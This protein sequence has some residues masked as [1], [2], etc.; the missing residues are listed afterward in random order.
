[1]ESEV[2]KYFGIAAFALGI[3][4]AGPALAQ[5]ACPP[6]HDDYRKPTRVWRGAELI[7]ACEGDKLEV[8]APLAVH[9]HDLG[10]LLVN[11]TSQPWVVDLAALPEAEK[12]YLR[13]HCDTELPCVARYHITVVKIDQPKVQLKPGEWPGGPYGDMACLK[14]QFGTESCRGPGR[15][16]IIA[17]LDGWR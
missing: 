7:L 4:F 14:D 10:N 16:A 11:P 1:M 15:A 3:A 13:E 9:E 5:D 17:T 12:E 8:V 2:N 6:P